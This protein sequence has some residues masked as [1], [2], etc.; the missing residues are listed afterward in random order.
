MGNDIKL[1]VFD[2]DQRQI[3]GPYPISSLKELADI[4]KISMETKVSMGKDHEWRPIKDEESLMGILFPVTEE[5]HLNDNPVI[6]KTPESEIPV[7]VYDMLE[8]NRAAEDDEAIII[9][10]ED[11]D[12]A[13]LLNLSRR[14]RDYLT[15]VLVATALAIIVGILTGGL[16][17]IIGL[18]YILSAW[19]IAIM[20][21]A[22]LIY[23]VMDAY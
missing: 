20:G 4:G 3:L 18:I 10:D 13:R 14:T 7:D 9:T 2:A 1:F 22:F 15:I 6:E 16:S 8:E 19:T 5:L 21:F 17:N 11:L 12:R 23:I